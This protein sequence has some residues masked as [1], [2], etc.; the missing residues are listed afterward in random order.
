M[1]IFGAMLSV[2][3]NFYRQLTDLS[4]PLPPESSMLFA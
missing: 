4:L 2:T 3:L 1:R